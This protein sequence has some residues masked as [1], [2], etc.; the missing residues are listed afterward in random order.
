VKANDKTNQ[1]LK[2]GDVVRM[3]NSKEC[4]TNYGIV[5]RLAHSLSTYAAFRWVGDAQ[6]INVLWVGSSSPSRV[7][8]TALKNGAVEVVRWQVDAGDQ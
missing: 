1:N 5:T 4:S 2:V 3:T 7:D 8:A 6:V